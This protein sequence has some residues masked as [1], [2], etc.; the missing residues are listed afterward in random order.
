MGENGSLTHDGDGHADGSEFSDSNGT[1]D[2]HVLQCCFTTVFDVT[3]LEF[4]CTVSCSRNLSAECDEYT[5]GS[6]AVSYTHLTLPTK[7]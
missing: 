2:V 6:T 4:L 7:A 5:F 1:A 3:C